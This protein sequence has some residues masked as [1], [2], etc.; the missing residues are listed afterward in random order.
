MKE[1]HSYLRDCFGASRPTIDEAD[2]KLL[3]AELRSI[4]ADRGYKPTWP[5]M[6][7]KAIVGEF[8][9]RQW[10]ELP[11]ATPTKATLDL[12]RSKQAAFACRAS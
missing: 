12:V 1:Y 2:E 7:F 6:Q 10:N 4:A 11:T 3:Y 8:P 9:P 5:A